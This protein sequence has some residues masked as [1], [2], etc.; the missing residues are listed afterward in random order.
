MAFPSGEAVQ[1]VVLFRIAPAHPRTSVEPVAD[2]RFATEYNGGRTDHV[3]I[4]AA[5]LTVL[6]E[7]SAARF[8]VECEKPFRPQPEEVILRWKSGKDEPWQTC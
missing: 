6:L 1:V 3:V 4:S 5:R 8:S 7:S 2:S